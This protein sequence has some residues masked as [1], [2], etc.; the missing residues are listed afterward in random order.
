MI[1][2][3]KGLRQKLLS[4]MLDIRQLPHQMGRDIISCQM[5]G[6]KGIKEQSRPS[7]CLR[8]VQ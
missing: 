4:S 6:V 8:T 3:R 1:L 2:E 5:G 7:A